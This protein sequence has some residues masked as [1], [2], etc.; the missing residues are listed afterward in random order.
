MPVQEDMYTRLF[1]DLQLNPRVR[2]SYTD[3]GFFDRISTTTNAG[4]RQ[5][6]LDACYLVSGVNEINLVEAP[7]GTITIEIYSVSSGLNWRNLYDVARREVTAG[8]IVRILDMR[9]EP[10]TRLV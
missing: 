4:S 6:V 10:P 8:I 3:A 1:R 7:A 2:V 9:T 5:S